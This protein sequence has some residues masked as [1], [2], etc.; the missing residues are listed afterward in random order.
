[1]FDQ[2]SP[3]DRVIQA[4]MALASEKPWHEI[5]LAGIAKKA[6]VPLGELRTIFRCKAEILGAF[7]R[8]V[9][10]EAL[11]RTGDVALQDKTARER[12][13]DVVMTRFDVLGPH[14]AALRR[15]HGRDGRRPR[16]LMPPAPLLASQ[17]WML[18]AAGVGTDGLVGT[19]LVA[20][21]AGAYADAYRTWLGED[22]R[23]LPK[24][25]ARL[26]KRLRRGERWLR[27]A[28]DLCCALERL[29]C[30]LCRPA[31]TERDE[32]G[33]PS[34]APEESRP[35]PESPPDTSGPGGADLAPEPG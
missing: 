5:T 15:I 35:E 10:D 9:D 20:G 1:M 32:G 8:A 23:G 11:R 17:Q 29:A 2:E 12:I 18:A 13:F 19:V 7:V 28:G 14:K 25:M 24:T 21:L 34:S 22:D 33:E 26:D 27:N 30:C 4:A 16:V 31:R 6:D 3:R